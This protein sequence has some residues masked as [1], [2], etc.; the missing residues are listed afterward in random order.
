MRTGSIVISDTRDADG[1]LTAELVIGDLKY[2]LRR[3]RMG[4]DKHHILFD[5]HDIPDPAFEDMMDRLVRRV[6][7]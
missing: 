4:G 7:G 6:R 3:W 2:T 5:V 1:T